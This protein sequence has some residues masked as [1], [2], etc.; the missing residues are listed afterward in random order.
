MELVGPSKRIYAGIINEYFFA[1]GLV[2]LSGVAYLLRDWYTIELAVSIPTLLYLFYGWYFPE[3]PRWLMNKGRIQEAEAIL[4]RAGEVNGVKL[5]EKILDVDSDKKPASGNLLQLFTSRVMLVRTLV[6]FFN[7]MVVSMTYYGLSLN[8]GNLGGD[9]YVNFLISGL[10]EFPAYTL[11]IIFLDRWGRKKMHCISM[12]LGGIACLCTILTISFLSDDLQAITTT[13]AM[14]GKL[15]SAA[16]FAIIY[17]FSAELYPTVVRNAG[18]GASSCCARIGGILAPYVADSGDLI[19]GKL[20]KAVPLMIF[21]AASVVAG[22]LALMLPETLGE[23]MPETIEDGRIFGTRLLKKDS[24]MAKFTTA[25]FCSAESSSSQYRHRTIAIT[26]PFHHKIDLS[27]LKSTWGL[28][29]IMHFD[30]ILEQIGA[31]GRYQL[32]KYILLIGAWILIAPF[33]MSSVFIMGVPKHST[34]SIIQK[35]RNRGIRN[36]DKTGT[37][38][39]KQ[40]PPPYEKKR[41]P[42]MRVRPGAQEK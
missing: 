21:G 39:N 4:R 42:D 29:W 7:W 8:T 31:L 17:I 15:G 40:K 25:P 35:I 14:I 6:I 23:S 5:G 41:T 22:L 10:V 2:V 28:G 24:A 11:V 1:L 3:S 12:L 34:K 16:G 26:L 38:A 20:G 32:Q 27:Y 19:G 30:D 36:Q 18:M 9:F 13:L 33:M 37:K